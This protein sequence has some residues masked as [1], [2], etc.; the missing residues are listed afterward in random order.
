[1]P[2]DLTGYLLGEF[3][4]AIIGVLIGAGIVGICWNASNFQ[5]EKYAAAPT[6]ETDRLRN[7]AETKLI[8]AAIE[9]MRNN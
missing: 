5:N 8:E 9:K 7:E 6:R 3:L 4:S 2:Y 1:M